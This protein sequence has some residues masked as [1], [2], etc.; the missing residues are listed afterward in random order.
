MNMG[1]FLGTHFRLLSGNVGDDA[2]LF[3]VFFMWKDVLNPCFSGLRVRPIQSNSPATSLARAAVALIL[4]KM[5][6]RDDLREAGVCTEVILE[7]NSA[8]IST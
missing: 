2:V 1:L 4:G 3:P 7:I 8:S 6:N 5:R